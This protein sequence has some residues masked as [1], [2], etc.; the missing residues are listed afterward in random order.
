MPYRAATFSSELN[1]GEETEMVETH[2]NL[3]RPS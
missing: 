3:G 1:H 2:S